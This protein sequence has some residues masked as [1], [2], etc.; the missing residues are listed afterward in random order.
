MNKNQQTITYVIV[1]IV[2]LVLLI[3]VIKDQMHKTD[4]G[5]MQPTT[6]N[7][8][9][10]ATSSA[11]STPTSTPTST[12]AVSGKSLS[13]GDA[14]KAYPNRFQFRASCEGTP[15]SISVKSGTTVMLD[16]RDTVSHTIKADKQTFYLSG[17]H[18]AILHTS[19]ITNLTVTCDGK[20]SVT[21][22][23]EK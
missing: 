14:I 5:G 20:N 8:P 12:A 7:S 21:L 23:V 3:W 13:Y 16:N 18:Y 17:L 2:I 4:Q 19:T 15:A 1:G 22:N 6:Q 11:T 10:T 9:T